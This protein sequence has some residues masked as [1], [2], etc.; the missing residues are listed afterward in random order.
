M[1]NFI[2]VVLVFFKKNKVFGKLHRLI[3]LYIWIL[4]TKMYICF[5]FVF[6]ISSKKIKIF[7]TLS[8]LRLAQ[9]VS[10]IRG[11][12]GCVSMWLVKMKLELMLTSFLQNFVIISKNK[13][14][15]TRF[16]SKTKNKYSFPLYSKCGLINLS[17]K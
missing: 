16:P 6:E 7:G 1:K 11:V 9:L 2:S 14:T 5:Y 8:Q 10:I 13:K 12:C 17:V 4:K 15:K 3:C